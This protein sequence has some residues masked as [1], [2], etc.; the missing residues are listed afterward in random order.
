[1]GTL[2]LIPRRSS[3]GNPDG[4]SIA[5]IA[6]EDGV[7]NIWVAPREDIG[8]SRPVTHDR[9][10]WIQQ[11]LRAYTNSHILY[12]QGSSGEENDR[13][14]CVDAASGTTRDLTPPQ[15]VKTDREGFSRFSRG[16]RD[17]SQRSEDRI[18]RP[19]PHQ[20]TDGRA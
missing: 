2:P 11:L 3:F 19:L 14:F 10:R 18:A 1:M 20:H 4:E 17:R 15:G 5:Y 8:R 16:D 9:G 6:P 13:L 7:L 12:L